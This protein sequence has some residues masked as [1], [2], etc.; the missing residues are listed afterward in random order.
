MGNVPIKKLLPDVELLNELDALE[1]KGGITDPL[2][3]QSGCSDDGCVNKGCLN[4]ECDNVMCLKFQ[5]NCFN[6][7]KFVYCTNTLC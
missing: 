4:T 3:A 7:A 5:C 2:G 1:V 6:P